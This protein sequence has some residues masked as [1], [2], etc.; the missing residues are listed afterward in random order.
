M[1]K[2]M[3]SNTNDALTD[4]ADA[5]P[6]VPAVGVALSFAS[7]T[8]ES[9][10]PPIGFSL[11]P[12]IT[13][14]VQ[15]TILNFSGSGFDATRVFSASVAKTGTGYVMLYGGLPFANNIQIGLATSNDGVTWTRYSTTPVISNAQSPAWAAFREV[16]V[17]LM[18]ESGKYELWFNGDNTNLGTD[19]GRINGFGYATSTDAVNWTIDLT[20]I[21]SA[22]GPGYDLISVTKLNGTY[23]AYYQNNQVGGAL[24]EATSSD[25]FN[26]SNDAPVNVPGGYSLISTTTLS[27]AGQQSILS[28]WRNLSGATYYG[29][30]TDGKNFTIQGIL[31]VSSDFGVVN[32]L[33]EGGQLRLYGDVD[34]GNVNWGYGNE[35][36]QYA[37]APFATPDLPSGLTGNQLNSV[38]FLDGL[39]KNDVLITNDYWNWDKSDPAKYG[40]AASPKGTAHKWGAGIG[41]AG[42]TVSYFF[43][44]GSKWTSAEQSTFQGAMYLWSDEANIKFIPAFS[45]ATAEL[46]FYRYGSPTAGVALD[47]GY[48][49]NDSYQFGTIGTTTI[50][51]TTSG[52]ISAQTQDKANFG[53]ITSFSTYGGYGID[54]IVHEIGHSIGLGHDGPYNGN[55]NPV[56]Q[57]LNATDTRLWSVMSYISPTDTS[58]KY[59]SSYTVKGTDWGTTSDG[60]SRAPYT[61]MGLD[62]I[63]AQ[64]L[65]G[66]SS[67][68]SLNTP[69]TFGFNTTFAASDPVR[70][71][72]DF[73]IDKKP[74]IT[75]YDSAPGNTLDL[76]NFSESATVDLH[77]GKFSSVAGLTN[78]IFIAYGTEIT[79][80]RGGGGNDTIIGNDL[81]DKLVGGSGNDKLVGGAGDD[82]ISG[83]SGAD[84]MAGGAGN[85]TYYVDNP[86]DI[87]IE[88]PGFGTDTIWA[89]VSYALSAGS[90]IKFLHAN[91]GGTGLSLSG[92]EFPNTI[93][94]SAGNDVLRGGAGNDVLKGGSGNDTLSGGAGA[95]LLSGGPGADTFV[96]DAPSGSTVAPAG[97]DTITD[98]SGIDGDKIDLHLIDAISGAAGNQSFAFIGNKPFDGTAG[99]VRYASA[100]ANT[101]I[102]GDINGDRVADFAILLDG[103][104]TFTALDFVL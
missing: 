100:G 87:V 67:G 15:G 60:Y 79:T 41:G 81:G 78:N 82:V 95:D 23:Y 53:D 1:P 56:T 89:S 22:V 48:Y 99:E 74:I 28:M 8:S 85:D 20:A 52:Y 21:R 5:T 97:R 6:Y 98:F 34:V 32:L 12:T 30:S 17:T 36:I 68:T 39:N 7:T 65:Y 84:R 25:G 33:P 62:I 103:A 64:Q 4:S 93:L 49:T 88:S 27:N 59:Y 92:N 63:A 55:V 70:K 104:H 54:S 3:H 45:E 29:T 83:G 47:Q 10:L 31:N 26:F 80:A 14:T 42:A 96:L 90:E 37:T 76:S 18:Y 73:N 11:V 40:L 19:Q 91:A 61:P 38:A 101:V 69:Q 66:V 102:S 50:G 46:V 86:S 16:P 71:F 43:D 24:Y 94:G 58:A 13:A 57:Q 2:W 77:P 44:T 51:T 72:F 75:I 9:Q 35:V